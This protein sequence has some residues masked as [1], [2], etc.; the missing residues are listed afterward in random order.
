[1]TRIQTAAYL[2]VAVAFVF[3]QG[4]PAKMISEQLRRLRELPDAG[5]ATATRQL[6]MEIRKLPA[7]DM[8]PMLAGQL[9]NLATEGDFGP[10]LC[11][12]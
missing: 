12:R 1:M 6:A 3:A 10:V 11:N 7:T 8:Q 5:R 2:F 9:S 4:D